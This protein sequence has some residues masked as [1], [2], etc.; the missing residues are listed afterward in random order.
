MLI[1]LRALGNDRLRVES[2]GAATENNVMLLIRDRVAPSG[3]YKF[4]WFAPK[5]R[6]A[7]LWA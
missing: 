4:R 6:K 1:P 7:S 2:R 5:A 3:L